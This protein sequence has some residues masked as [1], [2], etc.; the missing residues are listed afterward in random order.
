MTD[1][2][3]SSTVGLP[4][5]E[6]VGLPVGVPV[7][8][9]LVVL[10]GIGWMRGLRPV[11]VEAMPLVPTGRRVDVNTAGVAELGLLP[12]IGPGVA[13]HIVAHRE[14][15]GPFASV[16]ALDDVHRIGPKT[17]ANFAPFVVCGGV[18]EPE[19]SGPAIEQTATETETEAGR[20][21]GR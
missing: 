9:G 8:L 16:G 1:R 12:M 17:L 4:C 3:T 10:A 14:A 5:G 20:D 2:R 7:V 6:R 15:Y 18:G 21:G 19:A 11:P 13:G